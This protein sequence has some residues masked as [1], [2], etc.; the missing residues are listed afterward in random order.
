MDRW[1]SGWRNSPV[2]AADW[3]ICA[4]I[5]GNV[6]NLVPACAEKQHRRGYFRRTQSETAVRNLAARNLCDAKSPVF[7][8]LR[9]DVC[10]PTEMQVCWE[11]R[12][13]RRKLREF[14]I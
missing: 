2:R 3:A 14:S 9:R 1:L 11:W 8:G 10:D 6:W 13:V 4:K 12:G 7:M 5:V